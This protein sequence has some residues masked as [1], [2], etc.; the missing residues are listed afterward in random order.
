M[1]RRDRALLCRCAVSSAAWAGVRCD[2]HDGPARLRLLRRRRHRA[3]RRDRGRPWRRARSTAS[4]PQPDPSTTGSISSPSTS[5]PARR[6]APSTTASISTIR[7][8]TCRSIEARHDPAADAAV[9]DGSRCR[10]R[11]SSRVRLHDVAHARAVPREGRDRHARRAAA[12]RRAASDHDGAVRTVML[13]SAATALLALVVARLAQR[14]VA[15]PPASAPSVH[16]GGAPH[17]GRRRRERRGAAIARASSRCTAPSTRPPAGALL[18]DDVDRVP[19]RASRVRTA[20]RRDQPLLC[21][22]AIGLLRQRCRAPA[23][24]AAAVGAFHP[25]PAALGRA[26]RGAA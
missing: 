5:T 7:P 8:S 17:P 1:R 9:Q 24:P 25:S 15:L 23:S 22:L 10:S 26:E 13:A 20:Q 18:A 12:R 3:P 11:D 19:R 14:L 16:R 2:P 6:T 4:L 21:L